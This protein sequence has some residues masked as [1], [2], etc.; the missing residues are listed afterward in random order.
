M[1]SNLTKNLLVIFLVFSCANVF[2]QRYLLRPIEYSRP[3]GKLISD[4]KITKKGKIFTV[5]ND[6]SNNFVYPQPNGTAGGTKLAYLDKF[7]VVDEEG[8]RFK[9]AKYEMKKINE[10]AGKIDNPQI[11]GWVDKSKLLLWQKPLMKGGFAVKALALI[12]DPNALLKPEE[13]INKGGIV[14]CYDFPSK[15]AKYEIPK[16]GVN[17]FKFL[18][19]VKEENEMVLLSTSSEFT[20]V[21][22]ETKI[23]GWVPKNIILYWDNRLCIEP[24]FSAD[25]LQERKQK[26]IRPS[27]FLDSKSALAFKNDY[28]TA[29]D[30]QIEL[31]DGLETRMP[32]YK[33][34]MPLFDGFNT[35]DKILRTG[36]ITPVVD[37]SGGTMS[38][39]AQREYDKIQKALTNYRKINIVFVIDGGNDMQ[40]YFGDIKSAIN[41]FE[42]GMD[43]EM[44]QEF[45]LRFGVVV[46]RSYDDVSCGA[47][48]D[49]SATKLDLTDSYETLK[50]FLDRDGN[51]QSCGSEKSVRAMKK[52]LRKAFEIFDSNK[53]EEQSN[54]IISIG[55]KGD[56]FEDYA[57]QPY[58]NGEIIKLFAKHAVNMFSFQ[59]NRALTAEYSLFSSQMRE[60][61]EKGNKMLVKNFNDNDNKLTGD[62]TNNFDWLED[63]S[64]NAYNSFKVKK[65]EGTVK[66]AEITFPSAGSSISN[67]LFIEDMDD[68]LNR[69]TIYQI[70]IIK[71]LQK[72]LKQLNLN[73]GLTTA[74]KIVLRNVK[75]DKND[76]EIRSIFEGGKYQYFVECYT[77]YKLNGADKSLYD[78]ILF[79]TRD[80][81]DYLMRDFATL[82]IGL[83]SYDQKRKALYTALES[84]AI[85]Y[86]GKSE[87]KD[88]MKATSGEELLRKITGSVPKNMILS[89]LEFLVDVQNKKKFPDEKVDAFIE[90]IE[91]S[92]KKLNSIKN[93]AS[94]YYIDDNISYYWIPESY[95]P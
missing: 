82:E 10:D 86:L 78:R 43:S 12:K 28:K 75:I 3:D 81:L 35:T 93:D 31:T 38:V 49:I 4:H 1:C 54:Y 6:R 40:P 91:K 63:D 77:P 84:L 73:S 34:R 37:S 17:I 57:D 79:F 27:I 9:L 23:L 65:D 69:V 33:K 60:I 95:F 87:S 46:Y 21:S 48:G 24:N 26:N 32:S 85:S 67:Q 36:Y 62:I 80:E 22:A 66:L 14:R 39:D 41:D 94:F 19:V 51:K 70:E 74:M 92:S 55:S 59:Y 88:I 42:K 7:I 30:Q 29:S 72:N 25:A 53:C 61:M 83:E 5:I 71:G 64:K 18:F 13:Y 47:L 76:D 8:D 45:K 56:R 89:E 15:E 50:D 20:A 90:A 44:K 11:V 16:S 52:G 2:S 68:F 58:S